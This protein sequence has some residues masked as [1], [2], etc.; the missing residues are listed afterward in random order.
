MAAKYLRPRRGSRETAINQG[1]IL[2]R[3]EIFFEFPD[4]GIGTGAGKIKMGNGILTYEELPYFLDLDSLDI[5]SYK[6][7]FKDNS[8]T[9]NQTLLNTI[10]TGNSLSTIIG[11]LKKLLTNLDNETFLTGTL[12]ANQTTLNIPSNI[13]ADDN[14][15]VD[16]YTPGLKI[17][18]KSIS[19]NNGTFTLTFKAQTTNVNVVLKLTRY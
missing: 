2:K 6:V 3:G 14:V 10:K 17:S 13:S 1:I 8:A 9:S 11:A 16:V 12:A 15:L 19:F 4:G 7:T 18:P 5:S